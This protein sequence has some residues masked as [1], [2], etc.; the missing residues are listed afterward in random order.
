MTFDPQALSSS[1]TI[2]VA[3]A[4]AFIA[5]LWLSLI[6]WTYRDIRQRSRDPILRILAVLVV[7]V[8]FFPGVLIYYILRPPHT[9]EEEYQ[10]TLEEEALLQTIEESQFCP[11]CNRQLQADWIVCPNCHTRVKKKCVRCGKAIDL[12]WNICP[13]CGTPAPEIHLE[14]SVAEEY[15]HHVE[16]EG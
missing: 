2:G 15:S 6:F 8:L 9:L 10:Q 4:A 14:T 7:A 16:E 5:A 13:Y 3:F 11:G 12:P 1:V